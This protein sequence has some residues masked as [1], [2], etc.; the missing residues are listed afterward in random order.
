MKRVLLIFGTR[1][2]AI[3]MAMIIRELLT[4]PELEPVVCVTGQHRQMLDQV[5]DWFKIVP[6]YDLNLMAP[7]QSLPEFISLAIKL[8][9]ETVATVKPD[10]VLVQ[11]DTSTA[12]AGALAG[13]YNRVSVG[14]IEAGLRTDDIYNPFPEEANRRL[15]SALASLHFTPT[16]QAT[17]A[18]LRE[19]VSTSRIF[20]TGNTVIDALKWTTQQPFDLDINLPIEDENQRFILITAHRRENFGEDF[21]AL[22]LGLK[23]IVEKN[24]HV[25]LIYPV[26]LNP[27]V[28][29]P[30]F[31]ILGGHPRIHLLE[32]L[33][34][35]QFAHLLKKA[36]FVITDSGGVQEEAPAFGKPVLIMRRTTERQEAVEA[37]V[38]KLVG[39]DAEAIYASAQELLDDPLTY[40]KMSSAHSPFGDGTA[41]KQIVSVLAKHLLSGD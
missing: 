26:H 17:E 28:R 23:K 12:T 38:A 40:D 39:V 16:K 14:H 8:L 25:H 24:E 36:Y 15:I 19:N 13:F 41:A 18:L 29:A 5:L 37:G 32:P 1:P 35:P 27:N 10:V 2:E 31:K 4:Y 22:C 33:P 6:D 30:V 34:Y 20:Q 11:G 7:N 21:E 9:S 3:K